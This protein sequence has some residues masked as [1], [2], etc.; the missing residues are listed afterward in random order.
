MQTF[1][2]HK[3]VKYKINLS[4]EIESDCMLCSLEFPFNLPLAVKKTM[5]HSFTYKFKCLKLNL[6]VESWVI[7]FNVIYY[8][9][10]YT[11]GR[12]TFN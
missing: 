8:S 4:E 12:I 11:L 7:Y 2:K 3:I 1:A 9:N 5:Q 6:K 10:I